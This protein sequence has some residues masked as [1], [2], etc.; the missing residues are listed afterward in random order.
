MPQFRR[1]AVVSLCLLAAG[2]ASKKQQALPVVDADGYLPANAAALAYDPPLY[3]AL[4]AG[5]ADA[6]DAQLARYERGPSSLLGYDSD[7]VS[8]YYGV[9]DDRQYLIGN[10]SIGLGRGYGFG[11]FGAGY[12]GG[13][14]GIFDL[15]YGRDVSTRDFTRVR[16][17]GE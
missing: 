8:T 4:D 3:L 1:I 14:S 9:A 17:A 7:T 13:R 12:G 6:L 15:Y 5:E 11:R 2:C 10:G 16:P